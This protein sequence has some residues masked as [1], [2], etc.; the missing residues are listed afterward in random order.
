VTMSPQLSYA[1]IAWW[2]GIG[3]GVSPVVLGGMSIALCAVSAG[4]LVTAIIRI[5]AWQTQRLAPIAPVR[6]HDTEMT[7]A[8]HRMSTEVA[9]QEVIWWYHTR[10]RSE[11]RGECAAGGIRGPRGVVEPSSVQLRSVP[12]GIVGYSIRVL[13]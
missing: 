3:K 9:R 12:R 1:R 5:G 2:A 7:A 4:L 13:G 6:A 11:L 8:R 10:A